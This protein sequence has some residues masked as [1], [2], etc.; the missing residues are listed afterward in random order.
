MKEEDE[1]EKLCKEVDR[2]AYN[3]IVLMEADYLLRFGNLKNNL[4]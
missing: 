1:I 4:A 2:Y 3:G